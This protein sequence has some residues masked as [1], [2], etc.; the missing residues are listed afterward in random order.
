M[1]KPPK[2]GKIDES[3]TQHFDDLPS[4]QPEA[5]VQSPAAQP[6]AAGPPHW[7]HALVS[8]TQGSK[9]HLKRKEVQVQ[10][11][12]RLR[13]ELLRAPVAKQRGQGGRRGKKQ[14]YELGLVSP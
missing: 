14:W 2:A 10:Q 7:E 5:Q 8:G 4:S 12:P 6:Q 1:R 11:C 13:E 9:S 3:G